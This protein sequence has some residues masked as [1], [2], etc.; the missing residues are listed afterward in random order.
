MKRTIS[1]I[2]GLSAALILTAGCADI[3]LADGSRK[4]NMPPTSGLTR[5]QETVAAGQ[6]KFSVDFFKRAAKQQGGNTLVSSFSMSA[7]WSMLAPGASGKTYTEIAE[8]LGFKACAPEEIGSYY[9]R[10]LEAMAPADDSCKLNIANAIW[11]DR[12]LH[13]YEQYISA[14]EM[15]YSAKV[16]ELDLLDPASIDRVNDWVKDN[17]DGMIDKILDNKVLGAAMILTNAVYF[18]AKW[19]HEDGY[20]TIEKWFKDDNGKEIKKQF[21]EGSYVS[22]RSY[23]LENSENEKTSEPRIISLPFAS[24]PLEMVFVLPP[25]GKSIDDFIGSLSDSKWNRMMSQLRESSIFTQVSIPEFSEATSLSSQECIDILK[26]MGI[27]K[28]FEFDETKGF[29][30]LSP[31][32]TYV[33]DVR[34]IAKIEVTRS[35]AKA[36]AATSISTL[37]GAST[38]PLPVPAFE[39]FNADRPFLY[40]IIEPSTQSILFMG[41]IRQ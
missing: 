32:E 5:A 34:Q 4:S 33:G 2:I 30:N 14:T 13:P 19:K 39:T 22:G 8:T 27:R 16:T 17:T 11:V 18:N 15:Y 21:F 40:S 29:S 36:A 26:K 7:A 24:S 10:S 35:G 1:L 6:V 3:E 20:Q 25:E 37:Y 12:L 9:R 23:N 31:H 41:V 28:A 38:E